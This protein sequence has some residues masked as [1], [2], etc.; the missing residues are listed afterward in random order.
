[1]TESARQGLKITPVGTADTAREAYMD[2][3]EGRTGQAVSGALQTAAE[4]LPIE[5]LPKAAGILVS[6][7]SMNLVGGGGRTY[8]VGD[9]LT[10]N[11]R[12]LRS[13]GTS[14]R[15]IQRQIGVSF[16]RGHGDDPANMVPAIELET[17]HSH[18][19]T[20]HID[21][22]RMH[23]QTDL[24]RLYDDREKFLDAPKLRELVLD[25]PAYRVH[26]EIP[27]T[28]LVVGEHQQ[29]MWPIFEKQTGAPLAVGVNPD[30]WGKTGP[31][32][33]PD[34]WQYASAEG[35]PQRFEIDRTIQDL[36]SYWSGFPTTPVTNYFRGSQGSVLADM[37]ATFAGEKYPDTARV[38]EDLFHASDDRADIPAMALTQTTGNVLSNLAAARGMFS[39]EA[40]A[41]TSL[42]TSL[43][44]LGLAPFVNQLD[45]DILRGLMENWNALEPIEKAK[46]RIRWT[47]QFA[48]RLN[49]PPYKGG[50]QKW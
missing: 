30:L 14:D 48:E 43:K 41:N 29:T 33:W 18:R 8:N 39:E 9:T 12:R 15:D 50:L 6:P 31:F 26:K 38:L 49:R 16:V 19:T 24:K 46:Q 3:R 35:N 32:E 42:G 1:M 21:F 22:R 4:N 28:P 45:A 36:A 37:P 7:F 5:K 34:P 25:S 44:D 10:E 2:L 27:N 47:T 40:I 17:R 11:L 23:E 13:R 20:P